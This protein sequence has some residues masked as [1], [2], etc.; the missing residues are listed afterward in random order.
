M[1]KTVLFLLV[2]GCLSLFAQQPPGPDVAAQREAMKKLD[3][4]VGKWEGSGWDQRGRVRHEF[5]SAETVDWRVDG[6]VLLVEGRHKT[7]DGGFQALG[8]MSYDDAAKAYRFKTYTS[9]G[10]TV[11]ADVSLTG[12]RIVE[13]TFPAGPG[14]VRYVLDMTGKDTWTETGEFSRDGKAWSKFFEMKLT[15]VK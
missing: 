9:E 1:R 3:F 2:S 6:T 14:R 11:E 8:V 13:W 7:A 12:E 10:R 15:K 4:M 5:T